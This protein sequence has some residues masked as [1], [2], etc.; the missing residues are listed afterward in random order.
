MVLLVDVKYQD[1]S[2]FAKKVGL[3]KIDGDTLQI[4]QIT[5]RHMGNCN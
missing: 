2:D 3:R 1:L 5:G 4:L